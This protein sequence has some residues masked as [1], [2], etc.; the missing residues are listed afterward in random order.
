MA[1]SLARLQER[2]WRLIT[3][4]TGVKD[5]LPEA[6]KDDPQITPLQSW[7][8]GES[9]DFAVE[10]LDVYANMYFYRLLES[11]ESDYPK[12]SAHIGKVNF[13]NLVTDYLLAHPSQNP[14]LRYLGERFPAFVKES[15]RAKAWPYLSDLAALEWARIC[16]FDVPDEAYLPKEAMASFPPEEWEALLLQPIQALT[17][18]TVGY[19]VH[20]LWLSIERNEPPPEIT[21]TTTS[22]LVWRFHSVVYHRPLA[23]MEAAA[24]T[25]LLEGAPFA[26]LCE[27][28]ILPGEEDLSL[29]S[30][31][32]M[33]ALS[34]W[35]EEGLIQRIELPGEE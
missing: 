28:F 34:R 1:S 22:L 2:F 9:E 35:F 5:A 6:A 27:R 20:Q 14:S 17:L 33:K 16:V 21:P 18:L 25:F 19:P 23:E 7:I 4:P 10:R 30:E 11:L 15:E 3:A 8:K 31:R 26:L 29:A 32:M 24:L 13:H 12:I